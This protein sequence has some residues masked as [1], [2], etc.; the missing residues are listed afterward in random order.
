MVAGFATCQSP[1]NMFTSGSLTIDSTFN[2]EPKAP[3]GKVPVMGITDVA[4]VMLASCGTIIAISFPPLAPPHVKV[5]P[6]RTANMGGAVVAA[7]GGTY[8]GPAPPSYATPGFVA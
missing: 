5:I 6:P 3:P 7:A 4:V 1:G 8:P 2:C